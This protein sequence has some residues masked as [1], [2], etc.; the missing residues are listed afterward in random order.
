MEAAIDSWPEESRR[1]WEAMAQGVLCIALSTGRTETTGVGACGT[2]RRLPVHAASES[3]AFFSCLS[4]RCSYRYDVGERSLMAQLRIFQL[5][6]RLIRSP[7]G[8]VVVDTCGP[9]L[10]G[11][12]VHEQG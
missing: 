6:T 8:E 5:A 3:R 9:T 11:Q 12:G 1:K 7:N 10:Q 4:Q 2:P